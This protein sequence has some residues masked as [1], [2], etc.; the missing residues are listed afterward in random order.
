MA[1]VRVYGA[2]KDFNL[3][4]LNDWV[5]QKERLMG[6]VV[7]IGQGATDTGSDETA[8]S[9]DLDQDRLTQKFAKVKLKVGSSVAVGSN[10]A[11]VC[12]GNAFI[13]GALTAVF[14]VRDK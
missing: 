12:E 7:A 11:L 4:R 1:D 9:I 3:T 10:E 2:S 8:V 6:P 5:A 13:S 14:L